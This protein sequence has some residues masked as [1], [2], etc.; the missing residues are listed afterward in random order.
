MHCFIGKTELYFRRSEYAFGRMG[1]EGCRYYLVEKKDI[2]ERRVW[3]HTK[4][5]KYQGL[6]MRQ[7]FLVL[8]DLCV[9]P[10]I[11]NYA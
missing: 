1:I 9:K 11:L 10:K 2:V 6:H 4:D 5:T 8:R 3:F 7:V